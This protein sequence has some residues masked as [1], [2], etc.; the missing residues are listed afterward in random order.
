MELIVEA[1]AVVA[2]YNA[3]DEAADGLALARLLA[4]M[5]DRDLLIVRVLD[6]MVERPVLDRAAQLDVR[7]RV[8]STRRA[9]VAALPG[10]PRS[11]AIVPVLDARVA[12]GLHDVAGAQRA[13]FLVLGSSHHSR[14]GRIF[15]GATAELVVDQAPCPVAVA[16][17]GFRDA[18]AI[19]PGLIGC[20]YDGRRESMDAL[21]TATDLA[22]SAGLMLRVFT[23]GRG[24]A[25]SQVL[26]DAE[27]AVQER[28]DGAVV[29]DTV[30]LTG[31]P[32]RALIAESDGRVGL[33]VV[34]SRDHGPVQRAV[35]G[36]VSAALV[37]N[38]RCPVVVSPRRD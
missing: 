11:P 21:A 10:E 24:P 7:D 36:S 31:D 27:A 6:D 8:E 30:Q 5:T 38:A 9:L 16:P 2:A 23:V 14:L 12:R 34:G 26:A 19:A 17:P 3:T 18:G 32:A 13:E 4:G 33:L 20:A 25:A 35:M 15:M 37:R 28:A 1:R 22:E 29:V